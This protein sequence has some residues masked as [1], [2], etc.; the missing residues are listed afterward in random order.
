V[1]GYVGAFV[2][3]AFVHL[4]LT[5]KGLLRYNDTFSKRPALRAVILRAGK[6]DGD[7]SCDEGRAGRVA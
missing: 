2:D 5:G 1:A 6:D 3:D 4:L 7:G